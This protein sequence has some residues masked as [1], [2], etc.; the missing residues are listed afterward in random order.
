MAKRVKIE[1]LYLVI[2]KEGSVMGCGIDAPVH[3]VTQ[4]KIQVFIRTGKTWL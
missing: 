2:S 3:V 4:L 1:E